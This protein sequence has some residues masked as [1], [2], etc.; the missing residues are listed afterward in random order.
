L[1][2]F[3]EAIS[4]S[5]N[6]SLPTPAI[7]WPSQSTNLVQ[8]DGETLEDFLVRVSDA[9]FLHEPHG[10]VAQSTIVSDLFQQGPTNCWRCSI[11]TITAGPTIH[12]TAFVS[13]CN[14]RMAASGSKRS[15]LR[16]D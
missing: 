16:I 11:S 3:S 6:Q 10:L 2:V 8:A 7:G 4:T 1:F 12:S 14:G 9:E 15:C 13:S 5:G